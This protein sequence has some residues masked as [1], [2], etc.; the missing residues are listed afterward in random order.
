MSQTTVLSFCL[1]GDLVG[2]NNELWASFYLGLIVVE[3]VTKKTVET[4]ETKETGSEGLM[5]KYSW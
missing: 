2:N 4:K 5:Q 3:H 1:S